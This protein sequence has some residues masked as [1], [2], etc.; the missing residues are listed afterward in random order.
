ML[1]LFIGVLLPAPIASIGLFVLGI[2]EARIKV[3]W[4]S[5]L[6]AL[7][8]MSLFLAIAVPLCIGQASSPG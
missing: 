7:L 2:Y 3:V 8:N 4:A 5:V 1:L 6:L